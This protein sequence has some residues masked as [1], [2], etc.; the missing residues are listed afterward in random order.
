MTAPEATAGAG[1]V[2]HGPGPSA[3]ASTYLGRRAL[4][5]QSKHFGI[6]LGVVRGPC[7]SCSHHGAETAVDRQDRPIH[8]GPGV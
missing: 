6:L 7:A 3:I 4:V 8:E 1:P 2:E 5:R